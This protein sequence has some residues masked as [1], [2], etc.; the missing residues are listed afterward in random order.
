[1]SLSCPV[2]SSESKFESKHPEA[3]I[4]RCPQCDHCFSFINR[5]HKPEQYKTDYYEQD[6]VNWFKNPNIRLFRRIYAEMREISGRL[7]ILDVGCGK[8]DFLT[9]LQR[10]NKAF[11]L[12]GID[13]SHNVP[14]DGITFI[15]G[16][17]LS[18][19]HDQQY[20]IVVSMA[21]IEHM[22]DINQFTNKLLSLCKPGGLVF[23]MTLNDRSILYTTA[24]WLSRF[25][26]HAPYNRLYSKHH[27][28]HFNIKSLRFLMQET[29]FTVMKTLRHNIPLAAVDLPRTSP[30]VDEI[31]KMGVTGIFLLGAITGRTYLQTVVCRKQ[32]T[33]EDAW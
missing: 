13:L 15:Q 9:Y 6:H 31:M 29:G 20:D 10:R 32:I 14:V 1:M 11:R 16:D 7:S 22:P 2:C 3:D 24:R 18:L 28:H 19:D 12:T 17:F 5:L 25:G 23:I 33:R 4:Y 26:I 8:G 27:L 21:A 30:L